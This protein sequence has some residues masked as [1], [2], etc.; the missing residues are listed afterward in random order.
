MNRLLDRTDH[1]FL[2]GRYHERARVLDADAGHLLQRDLRTIVVDL[3]M[4]DQARV[5]AAG[6]QLLQIRLKSL[7]ALLHA[8]RNIFF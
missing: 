1:G 6:A 2:P 7:D 3:Q 4:L 8:R 5:R